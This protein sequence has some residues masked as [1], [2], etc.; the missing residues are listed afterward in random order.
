MAQHE[1]AEA[2]ANAGTSPR[3]SGNAGVAHN[4]FDAVKPMPQAHG[5]FN[6]TGLA[7]GAIAVAFVAVA[8]WITLAFLGQPALGL[9]VVLPV[10]ACAAVLAVLSVLKQLR[11]SVTNEL[12]DALSSGIGTPDASYLEIDVRRWQG[13]WVGAPHLINVRYPGT[14]DDTSPDWGDKVAEAIQAEDGVRYVAARH[15]PRE[16]RLTLRDAERPAGPMSSQP[17]PASTTNAERPKRRL[18]DHVE[19]PAP[20]PEDLAKQLVPLG[21]DATGRTVSWDPFGPQGHLLALGRTGSGKRVLLTGIVMEAAARAWPVWVID[22]RRVDLLG[23]RDWPNVQIVASTLDDQ[24]AVL[25]QAWRELESRVALIESGMNRTELEP[26]VVVVHHFREFAAAVTDA[27]SRA[28][29]GSSGTA[30]V[31]DRVNDLLRHGRQVNIVVVLSVQRADDPLLNEDHRDDLGAV[32]ALGRID[33]RATSALRDSD[34]DET[35]DQVPGRAKVRFGD[36]APVSVQCYWTIDPREV[37]R[38]DDQ[39]GLA[40]VE[41]FRPHVVTHPVLHVQRPRAWSD[42]PAAAWKANANA[43]LAEGHAGGADALVGWSRAQSPEPP[44]P[45]DQRGKD[46]DGWSELV[47]V[48]QLTPG[49][50]ARLDDDTGWVVISQIEPVE[51]DGTALRIEWRGT[52]GGGTMQ[53]S[54]TQA[55]RIRH[56]NDGVY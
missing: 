36:A 11:D 56:M 48:S 15:N 28:D 35:A 10:L 2:D 22:H 1:S 31:T 46:V 32:V 26:L 20:A 53:V 33:A 18:T 4:R 5:G 27:A 17:A 14:I 45:A 12:A 54:R 34:G 16:R 8:M 39:S 49:N 44:A 52:E 23:M 7:A 55:V 9:L 43:E 51:N 21:V 30:L 6:A 37:R 25:N 42:G 50:L 41:A 40:M 13:G 3:E 24:I 38:T 19:R 47:M 29:Q